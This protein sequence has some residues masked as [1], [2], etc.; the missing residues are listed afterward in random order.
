MHQRIRIHITIRTRSRQVRLG[1][2]QK[3]KVIP[4]PDLRSQQPIHRIT[5]IGIAHN[6]MK[7]AIIINRKLNTRSLGTTSLNRI[8]PIDQRAQ[9]ITKR[10]RIIQST[11]GI[12][13]LRPRRLNT[14]SRKLHPSWL[15]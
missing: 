12:N 1:P 13:Q 15:W 7:L 6:K 11:L 10:R 4:R 9:P 5:R 3:T 8:Q 2:D 14:I